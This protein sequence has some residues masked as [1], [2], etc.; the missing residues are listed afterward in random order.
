MHF[1][2]PVSVELEGL[3]SFIAQ[4]GSF[5]PVELR[6]HQTGSKSVVSELHAL[7]HTQSFGE[8]TVLC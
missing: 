2:G 6:R 1:Q 7:L 4:R 3:G 5:Q 8:A